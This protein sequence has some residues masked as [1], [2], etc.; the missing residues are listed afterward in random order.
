MRFRYSPYATATRIS[1]QAQDRQHIKSPWRSNMSASIS[2][3][4]EAVTSAGR[5]PRILHPR[6]AKRDQIMNEILAVRGGVSRR[7]RILLARERDRGRVCQRVD[8]AELRDPGK[9]AAPRAG[10][11][12]TSGRRAQPDHP[13]PS[14]RRPWAERGSRQKLTTT[15]R[16]ATL[17]FMGCRR[18]A[19]VAVLTIVSGT[20]IG[21]CGGEATQSLRTFNG[22][23]YSVL[24]PGKPDRSVNTVKTAAGAVRVVA[25]VSDSADR[26]SPSPPPPCRQD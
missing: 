21:G 10:G 13:S 7:V 4:T 22:P 11:R 15:G 24:M 6:R 2:V 16:R 19:L 14:R 12:A 23:G 8:D 18:T 20:L 26:R 17:A 25:Y 3:T 1:S 9:R 5:Q